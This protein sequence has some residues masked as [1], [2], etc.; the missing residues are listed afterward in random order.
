MVNQWG[1]YNDDDT[2]NVLSLYGF[3]NYD[4]WTSF[5]ILAIATGLIL[6]GGYIAMR[7]PA[8][9]L[10]KVT[11]EAIR[12]HSIFN[13]ETLS[14]LHSPSSPITPSTAGN[15]MVHV[16]QLNESL[17][18]DEEESGEVRNSLSKKESQSE[19][20]DSRKDGGIHISSKS[21]LSHSSK[22]PGD[23]ESNKSASE[24]ALNFEIDSS[25][26]I[27]LHGYY[28]TFRNV[29]YSVNVK[30]P[31]TGKNTDM[32]ILTNVSGRVEPKEMC[33]LMGA[34]GAGKSTLLDVLAD[35]KTIG[36][37]T[38]EIYINGRERTRSMM[39]STAYVMQD[40]AHI[41]SLTVKETLF[42]A[43]LLR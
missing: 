22:L 33:A 13:A 34:S 27:P 4:K 28:L 35:R 11:R 25:V 26:V 5:W 19:K 15:P 9:R 42:F 8:R 23:L 20:R 32:K 30:N 29:S 40:N 21:T 14:S 7:P 37:I 24:R 16:T 38:G 1:E 43:A 12:Q 3:S 36:D 31:V 17:L 18:D 2:G 41:G 10:K 39:K 6:I